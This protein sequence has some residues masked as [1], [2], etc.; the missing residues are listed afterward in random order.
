MLEVV[1]IDPSD[2]P[3]ATQILQQTIKDAQHIRDLVSGE[4]PFETEAE[5]NYFNRDQESVPNTILKMMWNYVPIPLDSLFVVPAVLEGEMAYSSTTTNEWKL[6]ESQ[7][8]QQVIISHS[9]CLSKSHLCLLCMPCIVY[10]AYVSCPYR[11]CSRYVA[12]ILYFLLD[13]LIY[14]I[15]YVSGT[16]YGTH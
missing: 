15:N 9:Y 10:I 12:D 1:R 11:L 4:K 16:K 14:M 5:I 2:P 3:S 6:A 8:Q 13:F 7:F